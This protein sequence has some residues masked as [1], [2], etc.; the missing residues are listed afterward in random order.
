MKK[1]SRSTFRGFLSAA[2]DPGADSWPLVGTVLVAYFL[3]ALFT[4]PLTV[5]TVVASLVAGAAQWGFMVL[6][7]RTVLKRSWPRRHPLVAVIFLFLVIVAVG[8]IFSVA[9]GAPLDG[10]VVAWRLA[11]T[12]V[13]TALASAL[14]DLRADTEREHAV[15]QALVEARDQGMILLHDQRQQIVGQL[16]ELLDQ[17]LRTTATTAHEASARVRYFARDQLRPLSHELMASIAPTLPMRDLSVAQSSWRPV[18]TGVFSASLIPP[19]PTAIVVTFFFITRT[20]SVTE[21]PIAPP[22]SDGVSVSFNGAQFLAALTGLLLVFLVTLVVS[23]LGRNIAGRV[24]PQLSLGWRI[25]FVVFVVLFI[26]IAIELAIQLA[27]LNPLISDPLRGGFIERLVLA[28]PVVMIAILVIMS[29]SIRALINSVREREALLTADLTWEVVRLN[30]TL[31]QERRFFAM[32]A[33]GP[34]QTAVN[35][36]AAR[37]DSV[38]DDA[39]LDSAWAAARHDL[40]EA[41]HAFAQGPEQNRDLVSSLASLIAAWD[42]LCDISVEYGEGVL[43]LLASDWIANASAAEIITEAIGNATMHGSATELKVF[44]GMGTPGELLIEILNNG[45]P[46]GPVDGQGLGTQVLDDIT[47]AWERSNADDGVLLTARIPVL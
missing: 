22:D 10:W 32:Q 36:A 6:A 9:L 4:S 40:E 26:A 30:E 17:A 45:Q 20:I 31:R 37:L 27:Y 47:I 41:I 42:G 11:I 34:L 25:T 33:H 19:L 7:H 2:T 15:Q 5:A 38:T 8:L 28:I 29:R 23:Y 18:L 35:A 39:S 46:L 43:E 14:T 1:K 13:A 3:L 44:L 24:L 16:L 12:L 21:A